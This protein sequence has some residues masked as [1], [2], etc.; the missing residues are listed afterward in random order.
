[1][2]QTWVAG[3]QPS[4]ATSWVELSGERDGERKHRAGECMLHINIITQEKL[5]S[6]NYQAIMLALLLDRY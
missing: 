2:Q 1:M 5:T 4:A 6:I 3:G